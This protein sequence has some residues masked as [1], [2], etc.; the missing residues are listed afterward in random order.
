MS[1]F[2]KGDETA[3]GETQVKK[4]AAFGSS[5][6]ESQFKKVTLGPSSSSASSSKGVKRT[7]T[8]TLSSEGVKR[9]STASSS[10]PP[11]SEESVS[12]DDEASAMDVFESMSARE[13]E[14]WEQQ[15]VKQL[16]SI[17][18]LGPG[19]VAEEEDVAVESPEVSPVLSVKEQLLEQTKQSERE[20][21]R[22][23]KMQTQQQ[24]IVAQ[25]RRDQSLTHLRGVFEE[26]LLGI[27]QQATPE[28]QEP[29]IEFVLQ[30]QRQGRTEHEALEA[31]K[32]VLQWYGRYG[33]TPGSIDTLGV[34]MSGTPSTAYSLG[35]VFDTLGPLMTIIG[36]PLSPCARTLLVRLWKYRRGCD[37]VS[38]DGEQAYDKVHSFVSGNRVLHDVLR[39]L[40][41]TTNMQHKYLEMESRQAYLKSERRREQILLAIEEENDDEHHQ[42]QQGHVYVPGG[43]QPHGLDHHRALTYF[44][45][46]TY[47]NYGFKTPAPELYDSLLQ[48][49]AFLDKLLL[50][51]E[52]AHT[53]FVNVF[54]NPGEP[55]IINPYD[56][57]L[58][59][60]RRAASSSTAT[61]GEASIDFKEW[62]EILLQ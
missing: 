22:R 50:V 20:L 39:T 45:D 30:L 47:S 26:L 21:E 28:N 53:Y 33:H 37:L 27:N 10:L 51:I 46:Q 44:L 31:G 8:S 5:S 24:N 32:K 48:E 59:S 17:G 34:C 60:R 41:T 13:D 12:R 40:S 55:L 15:Q 29:F 4:E 23:L 25:A 56:T 2:V 36:V 57:M 1:G 61:G 6:L 16:E 49:N 52:A 38:V 35:P 11:L 54:F 43:V 14:Q 62:L 9:S 18:Q 3:S 42:Q 7:S 58:I 19:E